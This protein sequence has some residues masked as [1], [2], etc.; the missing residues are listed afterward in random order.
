MKNAEYESLRDSDHR[1][2]EIFRAAAVAPHFH[3]QVEIAL[4]QNGRFEATVNGQTEILEKGD[5]CVSGSYDVHSYTGDMTGVTVV[6]LPLECL[7]R[8]FQSTK[9]KVASRHFLHDHALAQSLTSLIEVYQGNEKAHNGLFDEGWTNTVMGLLYRPLTFVSASADGKADTVRVVLDYIR[10]HYNEDL[11]LNALSKK[12]GYS[13]YHFSR[14]FNSLT[15]VGLKEYI[16]SVRLEA[17]VDKLLR[18]ES[19]MDAAL[20]SGFGSMRSFYREF[21]ARYNQTPKQ[22]ISRNTRASDGERC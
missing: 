15:N 1:T 8:F 18:G 3:A 12:F 16:N 21:N 2:V 17:A 13:P 6:T 7:Q 4:V 10:A 11:T 5:I 20:G 14:L 22:Y 19:A 9:G